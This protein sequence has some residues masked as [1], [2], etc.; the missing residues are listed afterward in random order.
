M[1]LDIITPEKVLFSADAQMV[2]VPGTL[3]DF[4]VLDGHAP[5]IST[6]RPGVIT[7]DTRSGEKRLVSI[8]GGIAEVV[9]E[10]CTILAEMAEECTSLTAGD[11]QGRIDSAKAALE[12][13]KGDIGRRQAEAKLAAAQALL[14]TLR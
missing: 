12:A 10:H 2:V 14:D 1:Q 13:A 9:P 4:G 5:F 8:V 3:G 7:I 6:I 11:A